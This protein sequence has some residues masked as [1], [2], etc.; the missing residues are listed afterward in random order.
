MKISEFA[1]K[2]GVT[3]KTLLHYDKIGLLK[4]TEKTDVGYRVYS[5]KDFLR[6]QH[7]TTLKFIGLSL[8]EI[9]QLLYETG[10]N[11]ES[12]ISIQKK[13]LEEKKKHI[14]SVIT[15]FNK[16]ENQIK[17]NEFLEVE[18]LIDIIKLTNMEVKVKEQ[19]KTAENFNLRGNLHSYN[20]NKTDWNKWC[21][22][23]MK[24]PNTARILELG[25]GT[26][27]LW[28]KNAYNIN[29][30]WSIILSDFS[31]GMLQST[32]EM[33]KEIDYEFMYQEIDA[34]DIPYE[35]ESFDV[36]IAR[37]MLYFVPD[38]E[39]ALYEIKRV[40]VKDGVFYATTTAREAMTE[41]NILVE[42]FDSNLGLNN[43]GMCDRFDDESG[44]KLLKKYFSEIK[45]DFLQ[46]KIVVHEAEPIISYKA[47]TI[48]GSSILVGEKKQQFTKY[49]EDYIKEKGNI[50]ITTKGCI[51]K[52][53]K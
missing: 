12:M 48:N 31:K 26:G 46:G 39:K 7:I 49:I 16:A 22:N 17:E 6:L 8:N 21:F 36:V 27:D 18:N 13:A 19:Y 45:I 23:Q 51:F 43:N 50:S 35:D 40:L 32:R 53:K 34:Q 28:Y 41:L 33:L 4:P 10:E 9:N 15:V 5:E 47:S 52:V 42:K 3:V 1:K 24:F 2:A 37:N 30:N 25:C 20:I 29:N 14:E 11:L 38:I 44:Q